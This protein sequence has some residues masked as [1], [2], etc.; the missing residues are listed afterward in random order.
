L[1]KPIQSGNASFSTST[2]QPQSSAPM[3]VTRKPWAGSV[4]ASHSAKRFPKRPGLTSSSSL[5]W[6]GNP[7]DVNST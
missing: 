7:V 3:P 1:P 6:A 2:R 4:A 5:S